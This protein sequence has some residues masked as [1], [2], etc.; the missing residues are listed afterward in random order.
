MLSFEP[1]GIMYAR[2]D[3]ALADA[4]ERTLRGLAESREIPWIYDRWFVRRCRR[5]G[6]SGCR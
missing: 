6:A 3:G 5:A 2:G 1:Y 4:V